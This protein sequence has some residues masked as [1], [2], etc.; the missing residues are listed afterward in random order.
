MVGLRPHRGMSVRDSRASASSFAYP[1]PM[2][3]GTSPPQI[4]HQHRMGHLVNVAW[5]DHRVSA[6]QMLTLEDAWDV[7]VALDEWREWVRTHR[8]PTNPFLYLAVREELPNRRLRK[9]KTG[10]SM[11]LPSAELFRADADGTLVDLYLGIIHD[12]HARWADGHGHPAPPEL[13][14]GRSSTRPR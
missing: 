9:T 14:A 12:L 10:A 3:D 4:W 5:L 2:C 7:L 11:Q 13:P 1:R 6:A 8:T